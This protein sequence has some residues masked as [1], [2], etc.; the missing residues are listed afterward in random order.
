MTEED[1]KLLN[2]EQFIAL[3]QTEGAVLVTAGAGSGKTR[4]LTHRIVFL[5]ENLG[6][7][8]ENLLAITFTNKASNEMKTRIT[9]MTDSG[10]RVWIS[11]FHSMCVKILRAYINK[12]D[13]RFNGNFSIYS[14]SDSEKV[15]KGLLAEQ[16]ISDDKIKKSIMFHLSA[17]KNNNIPLQKYK[18]ELAYDKD[19]DLIF[20]IMSGYQNNLIENN[21]LDFDDL[22]VKTYELLVQC[23]DIKE[24]YSRRFKYILVDEFQDTNLIQYDLIKLL[25]SV[26]KNVFVVGDEDQCIYTWRGANFRN[27]S[28]F[29]EDFENVKVFKLERNYRSTKTIINCANKLIKHNKSRIDKT[30]W[31]DGEEGSP[32]ERKE[33]YDE[34]G[35]ADFVARTIHDLVEKSGYAYNDFAILLRL[36]ALSFPFEEKLLAYNIPHK[37]FGGFKFYER[38]EIKNVLAYLKLFINPK[39]EQAFL[40][41]INFPRRAI[42]DSSIAKIKETARTFGKSMLEVALSPE[43]YQIP[44]SL[45]KKLVVFTEIYKKLYS[46]YELTPLNEFAKNVVDKFG[47]K[48]AF[49]TEREEDFEKIL[50][51][52][53]LLHSIETYAI[54]NPDD[55]LNDYLQS[56]SLIADIDS[57]DS[58]DNVIVATVHA[59]KGLEFRAVF[60][61][62]LE[63]KIFPISRAYGNSED[64]EE[65]RRLMYVGITRAKEKLFLTNCKT[66]YLYGHRDYMTASRF[67]GEIG[68]EKKFIQTPIYNSNASRSTASQVDF[69][70]NSISGNTISVKLNSGTDLSKFK[71]GVN[72]L[73]IKFGVGK[74]IDVDLESKTADIDFNGIGVKTLMLEIA[75]LKIID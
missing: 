44:F 66:R 33:V 9:Q 46:D 41:I 63:E 17:M 3:K 12:L 47:I 70:K 60:L 2:E 59:V 22:L 31:S 69:V 55:T 64:M 45:S 75:P 14:D 26:H 27:I 61:V 40:R 34:Q 37:I 4:L 18:Q 7:S 52:D 48:F 73:H 68:F 36:N 38:V 1:L 50:N 28:N 24:S 10:D 5:M 21:A 57:L 11:T 71:I 13:A 6:V 58:S 25:S 16:G 20:K 51:I 19:A 49:N 74:I 62:G 23:P 54:K 56:V 15:I 8:P 53:Q 43:M 42:G 29:K 39:D 67:L 72:V 35:E 65:E 32:I 30:L